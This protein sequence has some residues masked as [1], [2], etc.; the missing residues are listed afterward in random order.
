[1][2]NRCQPNRVED[3]HKMVAN[4]TQWKMNNGCQPNTV[5]DEHKMVAATKQSDE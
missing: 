5:E 1:M 2:N 4:P 3:E